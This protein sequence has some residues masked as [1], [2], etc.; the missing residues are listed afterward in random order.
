MIT[1]Q[2][3]EGTP[4]W[5]AL[6]ELNNVMEQENMP[7]VKLKVVGGFA[8]MLHEIRTPQG[9]TDIDY[10]GTPL[11]QKFLNISDQ[12][13]LKYNL[14][15]KWINNDIMLSGTTQE[16]LE[17]STGKLHFHKGPSLS[18]IDIEVLSQPDL[19]RMKI[20]AIDTACTAIE[21]EGDFT[22]MKDLPDIQK[23][24]TKMDYDFKDVRHEFADYI[25]SPHTI[26]LLQAYENEGEKGAQAYI[27]Q[28]QETEKQKHK[29][30]RMERTPYKTSSYIQDLLNNLQK[31]YDE[32][33]ENEM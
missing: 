16:D 10:V 7:P 28:M 23:L 24:M 30:T 27:D 5:N 19:L 12:I 11:P 8:L 33:K 9:Q 2:K 17:F 32:E 1:R 3:L 18:K 13:G 14:G 29:Q 6:Q 20:I 21:T 4:M 25:I 31:K 15:K 26:N 22:R